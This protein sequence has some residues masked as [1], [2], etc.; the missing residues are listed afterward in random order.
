MKNHTIIHSLSRSTALILLMTGLI[1]SCAQ[2]SGGD[3]PD[4]NTQSSD[5][6]LASLAVSAGTLSPSFAAGTLSY[7]L[8]VGS[9]TAGIVVTPTAHHSLAAIRVRVNG[10]AYAVV[11]SGDASETLALNVGTNSVEAQ[12]TAED[13]TIRTYGITVTRPATGVA[14]LSA[15]SIVSERIYPKFDTDV[16]TYSCTVANEIASIKLKPTES[17]SGSIIKVNGTTVASGSESQ[18][19]S[20]AAGINAVTVSV[21]NGSESKTYSI[22]VKRATKGPLV[23]VNFTYGEDNNSSWP[24]IYAIWLEKED[25]TLIQNLYVCNR[26]INGSLTNTALPFWNKNRYDAAEVDGV[27][28]ATKAKQNFSVSGYLKDSDIGKFRICFESDHSFDGN[29][30]FSDQPALLYSALVDR[31]ALASPYTLEFE[32]WTPNEGTQGSLKAEIKD[33]VVGVKQTL[34]KLKHI[35]H[36]RDTDEDNPDKPFGAADPDRSSTRIV[37][38]ITATVE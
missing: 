12:V 6:A 19:I 33:I 9:E 11:A 25:G 30:W 32:A 7:A 36:L 2:E 18:A 4:P 28:G 15:L 26:L 14:S 17:A 10:G 20:L 16:E 38:G 24:N 21:T 8:S 35:T 34:G 27:S 37:G 5:A 13:G 3:D 1:V 31:S 29:D 23:T 22:N